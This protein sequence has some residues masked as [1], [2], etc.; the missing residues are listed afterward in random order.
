MESTFRTQNVAKFLVR[1]HSF[2]PFFGIRQMLHLYFAPIHTQEFL[3]LVLSP[4]H[5]LGNSTQHHISIS[6]QA[7]FVSR[8]HLKYSM[9]QKYLHSDVLIRPKLLQQS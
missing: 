7:S 3:V 8:R 5:I 2:N 1:S 4:Q 6:V 9:H